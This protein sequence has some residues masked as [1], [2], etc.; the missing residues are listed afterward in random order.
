MPTE[1]DDQLTTYFEWIE[2]A[3]GFTLHRSPT[4][5]DAATLPTSPDDTTAITIRVSEEQHIRS[6]RYRI[7]A[8]LAVAAA[9]AGGLLFINAGSSRRPTTPAESDARASAESSPVT[10]SPIVEPTPS[11][12]LPST[13]P[14]TGVTPAEVAWPIIENIAVGE[15]VMQ[16]VQTVL[17]QYGVKVDAKESI[18]GSGVI[19]ALRE[20]RAAYDITGA[21][22]IQSGTNG[23]VTEAEY[24]EMA[25]ILADLPHVYF[26]TIKA[27]LEWVPGNNALIRALP[28]THP[29][30]TVIDWETLSQQLSSDDLSQ[31]DG[32]VHLNSGTAVRF[33]ANMILGAL[34][35]P[36][37]PDP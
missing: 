27:P 37:I 36:L 25:D 21:V 31:S 1:L 32:G 33:Y 10:P 7:A 17:P 29:N 14:T 15:S 24:D 22:V 12:D 19:A 3:S 4:Q 8:A 2:R 23:K 26:L 5:P 9:V 16:A 20:L 35:K 18:Q 30:V 6:S 11:S 34:G 13:A 28:M